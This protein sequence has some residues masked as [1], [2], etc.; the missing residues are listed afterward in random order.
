M[1]GCMHAVSTKCMHNNNYSGVTIPRETSKAHTC[2][3]FSMVSP[4]KDGL[5]GGLEDGLES[6]DQPRPHSKGT[7]MLM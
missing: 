4:C 5:K 1:L 6:H 7:I 3:R 2:F